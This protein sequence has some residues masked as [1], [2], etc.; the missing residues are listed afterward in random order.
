MDVI[1]ANIERRG[2]EMRGKETYSGFEGNEFEDHLHSENPS[3]DHVEDVHG[4]VEQVRLA[5]VLEIDRQTYQKKK[6][7]ILYS[8]HSISYSVLCIIF[9]ISSFV[10]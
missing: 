8:K 10:H 6:H 1:F 3:K 5:M 7:Y 4:I 2:E 9:Y